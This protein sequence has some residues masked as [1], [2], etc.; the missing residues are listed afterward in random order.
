MYFVYSNPLNF[1]Y[2]PPLPPPLSLSQDS[3]RT[4]IIKEE[5]LEAL[6]DPDES[7]QDDDNDP[8]YQVDLTRLFC[9][10]LLV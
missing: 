2:P 10:D 9:F 8:D 3:I 6:A 7:Q 1:P 4:V 5:G